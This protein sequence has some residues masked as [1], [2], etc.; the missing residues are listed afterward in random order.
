M[1]QCPMK[2]AVVGLT[3]AGTLRG[4]LAIALMLAGWVELVPT[5]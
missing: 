1:A 4:G 2:T 3:I 5:L